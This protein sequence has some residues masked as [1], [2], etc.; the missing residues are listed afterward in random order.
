MRIDVNRLEHVQIVCEGKLI[1]EISVGACMDSAA[2]LDEVEKNR[3]G[4]SIFNM[5]SRVKDWSGV[6]DGI[7]GKCDPY[8][9]QQQMPDVVPSPYKTAEKNRE[10]QNDY[11]VG[12]AIRRFIVDRQGDALR[13][14]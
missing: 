10:Y 7:A 12:Q 6:I 14:R 1:A 11:G 8:P 13:T 9:G 3:I 5:L 4:A 2:M